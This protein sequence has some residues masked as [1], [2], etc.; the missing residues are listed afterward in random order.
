[1]DQR[2]APLPSSPLELLGSA[3]TTTRDV[4]G[5][6]QVWRLSDR[7]VSAGVEAAYRLVAQTHAAALAL[8]ADQE[9]ADSPCRLVPPRRKPGYRKPTDPA[10]AGTP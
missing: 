9:T 2:T 7:D 5:S 10:T 1:M 6:G 4:A 3:A 8:L